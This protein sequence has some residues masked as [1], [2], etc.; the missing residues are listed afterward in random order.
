MSAQKFNGKYRIPSARLRGYDYA[1]NGAYFIT[2]CTSDRYC[3]FGAIE[4]NEMLLNPVGELAQKFWNMIPEH[5]PFI[6]LDEMVVMP[7]HVHGVLWIDN[8][9]DRDAIHR[10]SKQTDAINRISEQTDAIN[11]VSEQTDAINGISEQTDAMNRVSTGGA[12][13]KNNPMFHKNISRVMRW[14]KGRCTFEINKKHPDTNFGWQTRFYDHIIR[15][16]TALKNIRDYIINNPAKWQS[17][18]N[19]KDRLSV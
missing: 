16:E 1:S 9:D 10:V 7:N 17:D 8:I 2:I 4:N 19:N 13:G 6:I 15:D 5:F 11:R 18:K 14:Y 3:F 12:T